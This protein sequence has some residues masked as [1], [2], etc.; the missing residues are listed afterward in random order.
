MNDGEL[1]SEAEDV[2]GVQQRRKVLCCREPMVKNEGRNC[3]W[4][5]RE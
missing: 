5:E 2:D 4:G 1:P 3:V